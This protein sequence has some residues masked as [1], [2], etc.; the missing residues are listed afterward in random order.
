MRGV[1]AVRRLGALL[2]VAASVVGCYGVPPAHDAFTVVNRTTVPVVVADGGSV[3]IVAACSER[4]LGWHGT[5]GGDDQYR[6]VAE[7]I[8]A[9]AWV[10]PPSQVAPE[11]LE[12]P[13]VRRVVVNKLEIG[14]AADSSLPC[15]GTPPGTSA[16]IPRSGAGGRRLDCGL[17]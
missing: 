1:A 4:T 17:M 14:E 10:L 9:G 2:V 8:P 12:G 5:W 6:P 3:S 11:P 16:P 15:D 13:L 7:P